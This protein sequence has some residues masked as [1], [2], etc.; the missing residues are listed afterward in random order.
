MDDC[1]E[2]RL[3]SE[4]RRGSRVS[5]ERLLNR[6]EKP[7]FNAAYR[8]LSDYED[9]RDVT[10]NVFLKAFENL[11]DFDSKHRFFSW[12]YRIAINEALNLH[13][14]RR[15]FEPAEEETARER[16]TPETLLSVAELSQGVQ[17]ALMSIELDYRVV[18][19]LRH[20]NDCSY[21]DISKI[22]DIPEKTVKS[23]LFT[24][25]SLLR[26]VLSRRGMIL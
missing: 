11:E 23:R 22:L 3:V 19:V 4:S 2:A 5:F 8:I 14:S 24:A 12:I 9:A 21:R 17:A 26:E 6:Y 7:I 16:N 15:R 13:K 18:I 20:F 10:Q 1:E 25:R